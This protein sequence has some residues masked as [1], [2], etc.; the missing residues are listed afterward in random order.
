MKEEIMMDGL[1]KFLNK[2]VFI[3]LKSSRQY[4]GKIQKIT[5][6]SLILIDKFNDIV[7][8]NISEIS[9]MEVEE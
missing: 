2:K 6:N 8:I 9:S 1:E 5:G 4:T 7:F 3:L